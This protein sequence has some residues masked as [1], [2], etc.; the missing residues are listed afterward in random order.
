MAVAA[1]SFVVAHAEVY[2]YLSMQL[3]LSLQLQRHQ[4]WVTDPQQ[5]ESEDCYFLEHA[6]SCFLSYMM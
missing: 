3:H 6:S 4:A 2:D 5:V 1:T